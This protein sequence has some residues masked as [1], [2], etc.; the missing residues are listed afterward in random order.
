MYYSMQ[1]VLVHN[2]TMQCITRISDS[3]PVNIQL[4]TVCGC[5]VAESF[6]ISRTGQNGGG[7][8]E[9]FYIQN[10]F[11]SIV[12]EQEDGQLRNVGDY[13]GFAWFA[14]RCCR[15]MKVE[16]RDLPGSLAGVTARFR[17]SGNGY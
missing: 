1:R 7:R 9:A 13:L 2:R 6:A 4:P 11:V 10:P 15:Q 8:I 14:R 3:H 16:S 5:T 12:G 17:K